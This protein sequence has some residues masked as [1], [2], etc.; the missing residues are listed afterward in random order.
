MSE[1][2]G[3]AVIPPPVFNGGICRYL[4]V[5]K[6]PLKWQI[7]ANTGHLNS[8]ALIYFRNFNQVDLK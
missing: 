1:Q 5:R 6:I 7:Q 8:F 2:Q 4:P 3:V